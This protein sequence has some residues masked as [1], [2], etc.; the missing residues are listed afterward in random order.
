[1]GNTTTVTQTF[2]DATDDGRK[3][4]YVS[5]SSAGD[6]SDTD[7]PISM[8][9]FV[10]MHGTPSFRITADN[11]VNCAYI[12]SSTLSDTTMTIVLNAVIEAGKTVV[13]SAYVY[14]D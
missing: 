3:I 4:Y 2:I 8:T 7:I 5:A 12:V 11:Q 9:R 13:A 6:G 1:M 10:R 14:G